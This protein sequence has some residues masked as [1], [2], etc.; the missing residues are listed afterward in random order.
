MKA[1]IY[2]RVSTTEQSKEGVSLDNQEKKCRMQAELSEWEITEVISDPGKS[3]KDMKRDGV[4]QVVDYVKKREIGA[5][6]IYKLDR[7]TRNVR[8]LNEFIE[9]CV[10]S[11]VKLISVTES[12]NTGTAA[13]RMVINM[14]GTVA[15]W[16]RETIGERVRDAMQH[17]KQ[18]GEKYCHITPY[19]KKEVGGK[20]VDDPGEQFYIQKIKTGREMK[21]S[22]L[23]I[24]LLLNDANVPTRFG[25]SWC[26]QSVKK[27]YEDNSAVIQAQI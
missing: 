27:I 16:E 14:L 1:I 10:K 17:K 7:L 26:W 15:Q 6:I 9:L 11:D 12:L 24:S 3:A 18:N 2:T 22:W 21:T 13:G 19:G 25:K 4:Q 20:L 8:D 23:G 5:I